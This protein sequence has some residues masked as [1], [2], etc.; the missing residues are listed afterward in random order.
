[1]AI[2][3][4]TRRLP[5]APQSK[6][7]AITEWGIAA[8]TATLTGFLA[9]LFVKYV[10][11]RLQFNSV[12]SQEHVNLAIV[13]SK[14]MGIPV[15]ALIVGLLCSWTIYRVI[16]HRL[17]SGYPLVKLGMIGICGASLLASLPF[18]LFFTFLTPPYPEMH[19]ATAL[20]G[21][22]IEVAQYW[23]TYEE[24]WLDVVV[25]RQDGKQYRAN[26]GFSDLEVC[27]QLSTTQLGTRI[28]FRCDD[29]PISP[30]TPYVDRTQVTL[31]IGRSDTQGEQ[32][33]ADLPFAEPVQ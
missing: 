13:R 22:R 33:I 32:T 23:T 17:P 5:T 27:S 25:T 24:S 1:M 16:H 14:L 19:I 29:A 31:S 21:Y 18:W 28:Y 6:L 8:L 2:A 10:V 26:I 11:E 30:Q 12:S 20:S 3:A 4:S 15:I 9:L 7:T